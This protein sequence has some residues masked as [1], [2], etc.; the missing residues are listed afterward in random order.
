MANWCVPAG[1]VVQVR[2]PSLAL[3][4]LLKNAWVVSLMLLP[5][6]VGVSGGVQPGHAAIAITAASTLTVLSA[7]ADALFLTLLLLDGVVTTR[8]LWEMLTTGDIS[9]LI[10]A[11]YVCF[12]SVV[13]LALRSFAEQEGGMQCVR[14]GITLALVITIGGVVWLGIREGGA[15]DSRIAG[16]FNNPNQLGYFS[17]CACSAL[18]LLYFRGSVG[19]TGLILGVMTCG[20]L[21]ALSLSK[22]ALVANAAGIAF[23]VAGL[24]RSWGLLLLWLMLISIPPITMGLIVSGALDDI[25]VVRR[26]R[27]IGSD[28]DDSLEARGYG[29][30]V[31][32]HPGIILFGRNSSDVLDEL[33]HEVH[34][35]IGSIWV[36]YGAVGGVVFLALLYVWWRTLCTRYGLLAAL[37]IAAP[38]LLYGLTHNGTRATIFWVLLAVSQAWGSIKSSGVQKAIV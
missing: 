31:S 13:A 4:C 9:A 21:T 14:R 1:G 26:L 29:L 17:T 7:R 10:Q 3:S 37:A 28:S 18:M 5:V 36:C 6:Y 32:D 20:M 2:V 22:A 15:V 33:G 16:T 30:L 27:L 25:Q 12:N 8:C 19:F 38:P 24:R 11:G 35:S 34:S 23:G